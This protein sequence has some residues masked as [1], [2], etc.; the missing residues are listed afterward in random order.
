MARPMQPAAKTK[1]KAIHAAIDVQLFPAGCRAATAGDR[2][3]S[4]AAAVGTAVGARPG[5]AIRGA[6]GAKGESVP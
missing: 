5:A 4:C 1:P 3:R 2:P 6:E